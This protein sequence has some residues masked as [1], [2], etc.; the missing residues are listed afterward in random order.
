MSS[1]TKTKLDL[2]IEFSRIPDF[3]ATTSSL[4]YAIWLNMSI[5]NDILLSLVCDRVLKPITIKRK[6]REF[7]E[8]IDNI[9]EVI[10]KDRE[11]RIAAYYDTLER[12]LTEECMDYEL[13][14]SLE[15][16]KRFGNEYTNYIPTI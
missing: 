6:V 2:S 1:V 16:I 3:L 14:E 13:Y 9:L 7:G 5:C 12:F 8:T 10:N 4:D 15:N 11:L